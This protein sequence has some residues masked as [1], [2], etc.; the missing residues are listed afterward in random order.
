MKVLF[1]TLILAL[2]FMSQSAI[3]GQRSVVLDVE[4]MTCALCPITVS[5]AL[6]T[7]KG[8]ASVKVNMKDKTATVIYDDEVAALEDIAD[9]PTFAG[10]PATARKSK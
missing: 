6:K 7:V 10:Y 4:N 2:M 1:S 3:A 8:V 5:K 9:A